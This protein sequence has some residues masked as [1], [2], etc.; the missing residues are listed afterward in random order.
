M[1]GKADIP[2]NPPKGDLGII[3]VKNKSIDYLRGGLKKL[4]LQNRKT[5]F[6]GFRG[7][8]RHSRKT[9]YV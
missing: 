4:I 1:L 3:L 6:G 8:S 5:P 7:Y 9:L 2:L